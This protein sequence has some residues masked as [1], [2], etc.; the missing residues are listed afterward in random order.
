MDE[1][2][3]TDLIDSLDN[4]RIIKPPA[5]HTQRR[6][7]IIDQLKPIMHELEALGLSPL[8]IAKAMTHYQKL[9][10]QKAQNVILCD[11]KP[12]E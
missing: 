11:L 12:T 3:Q 8:A 1:M 9:Y 6:A 2:K 5:Q 4:K 10:F 7:F